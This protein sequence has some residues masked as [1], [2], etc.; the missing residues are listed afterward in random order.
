MATE[1]KIEATDTSEAVDKFVKIGNGLPPFSLNDSCYHDKISKCASCGFE[2]ITGIDGSHSCTDML[3]TK[4]NE[5]FEIIM[6][7]CNMSAKY[8]VEGEDHIC[9]HL[10]IS[11]KKHALLFLEDNGLAEKIDAQVYRL[12][13][14]KLKDRK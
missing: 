9:N 2:W 7:F 4:L 12:L 3:L 5:A 8:I 14:D 10:N 6:D 13:F 1:Q 11:H